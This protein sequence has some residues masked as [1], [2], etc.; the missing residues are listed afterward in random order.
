M[1][2][3]FLLGPWLMRWHGFL[4]VIG[5]A[6]G[7]LL[8]ALQARRRGFDTEIIYDLFLPVLIWGTVGARLWHI[9][10]PP[11]S[12]VQLGLTRW[13][14]LTHPLDA[15]A[16]WVGG[17]GIPGALIGGSLALLIFARQ[18]QLQFWDLTDLL[19]PGLALAQA[20]GRLGDYFNQEL[21]GLP[22]N[23]PWAIFI[24]P[25]N[26]LIGYESI[27]FYHPLFIYEAALNLANMFL[28]LWL[29]YKFTDRFKPGSLF[30]AYLVVYSVIR[31]S[32]EFLRLDI[33]LVN[34]FN[35]NQVFFAILFVCAGIGLYLRYR[36]VQKL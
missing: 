13:Y 4:L 33:A 19:A 32:L 10:T 6:A 31:F 1:S 9:L 8:S 26:R 24:Q 36:P 23:L 11:L 18:Q 15:L 2:E 16:F 22:S 29:S 21:Y 17:F 12:S 7:A 34:G 35:I 27:E 25:A 20:I 30:L 3:G 28:L 14:Y 5:I